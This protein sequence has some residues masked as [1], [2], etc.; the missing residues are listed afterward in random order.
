MLTILTS[1]SEEHFN[2]IVTILGQIGGNNTAILDMLTMLTSLSEEN[3][4]AILTI[5]GQL[6]ANN[7]VIIC[8][9]FNADLWTVYAG[10]GIALF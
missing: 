4:A 9:D 10:L 5:L 8:G 6:G 7:T 1:L 2:T 3:F